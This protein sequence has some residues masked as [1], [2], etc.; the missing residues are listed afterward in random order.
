MSSG[1]K[2]MIKMSKSK[3][4]FF[5]TPAVFSDG[6]DLNNALVLGKVDL[7]LV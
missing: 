3:C 2:R 6:A 1:A 7:N 4:N 5:Q